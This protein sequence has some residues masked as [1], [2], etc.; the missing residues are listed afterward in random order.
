MI[1]QLFEPFSIKGCPD[2]ELE[3]RK[4]EQ[5]Y[6]L[7]SDMVSFD[8]L[9]INTLYRGEKK[10]D[11]IL[12]E[13]E[14]RDR[15]LSND[16]EYNRDDFEI[17]QLYDVRIRGLRDND[18][19]PFVFL[20]MDSECYELRLELKA[21]LDVRSDDEFFDEL[22]E[23][24]M[25]KKV[26]MHIIVRLF[27]DYVFDEIEHLRKLFVQLGLQGKLETDQ[28]FVL[29][30]ASGFIPNTEAHFR[31]ILQ[32]EWNKT[33][34]ESVEFASYA[35]KSGEL[36]GIAFKDQAG[37][38]GRN[39]LGEYIL[40]KKQDM[41]HALKIRYKK[42]E[43]HKVD[44]N[45]MAEYYAD[46]DGYASFGEDELRLI[47]NLSFS[48]V[49][50]RKNGSLL[51]GHLKGFVVDVTCPNPNQDAIGASVILE[52]SDIKV[53]GSVA[54]N[55]QIIG[56]KVEVNGQTHQ[57]SVIR[58]EELSID[59]HKGSAFGKKVFV[60][61]LESG[62]VDGQNVLVHEANGGTMRAE[63]LIVE[64]LYSRTTS[65]IAHSMHIKEVK[66]G[67]NR[68]MITSR[69]TTQIQESVA[70]ITEK[71][72]SNIS[73]INTLLGVLNKDIIHIRKIKPLIEKIKV[74]MEENKKNN[75]PNKPEITANIAQYMLLLR[76]S[77]Y[78]KERLLVLQEES[79]KLNAHLEELDTYTKDAKVTLELPWQKE[80]EIVFES[81]F[82][83]S[84]D[85]L[86]LDDGENVDIR[87]DKQTLKLV[88][89]L[90][91]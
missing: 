60:N 13:S 1:M 8:I 77:K 3:V 78:F 61:S 43:F 68:V 51:G 10:K 12:L 49:S 63:K 76:R 32:D 66:G 22:Y 11:F 17:K 7:D 27:G 31:F 80:N 44:N 37:I 91:A 89:E 14:E 88:R 30:K 73:Q 87:I 67:D 74:I 20:R 40:C 25:R 56:D 42:E 69:A 82:P 57:S 75:K 50:L 85:I 5:T 46:Q 53:Y 81:F 36:V 24:I 6:A 45:D 86:F 84:R 90:R 15:I 16:E 71:I 34:S 23:E 28:S 41:E 21:G 55:S 54:E 79:K 59:K 18:L 9:Q 70:C 58:A 38:S 29:T 62:S 19:A 83:E 47:S 35:V 65:Y 26:L 2:V 52:A 4:V 72:E 33:H 48:E 64:K 39:L